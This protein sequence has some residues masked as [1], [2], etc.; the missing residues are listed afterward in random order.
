[1]G[2]KCNGGKLSKERTKIQHCDTKA[3]DK[4]KMLIAFKAA[5]PTAFK[6]ITIRTINSIEKHRW[7]VLL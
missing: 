6:T 1:M 3:G 5:K 2:E 7:Q 4:E